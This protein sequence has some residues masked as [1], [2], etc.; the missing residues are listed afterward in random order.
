MMFYRLILTLVCSLIAMQITPLQ[1]QDLRLK[2]R[3][4]LTKKPVKAVH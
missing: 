4:K 1:A 2:P 3:F